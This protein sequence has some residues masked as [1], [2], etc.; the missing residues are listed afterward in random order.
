MNR[1][2][3]GGLAA[4]FIGILVAVIVGVGVAI[5]VVNETVNNAS[6]TGTAGTI[7]GYL[8]VMMAL[9]MFVAVAALVR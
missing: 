7:L 2:G 3:Q 9:V 6:V 4:A 8:V 5:P 1:K